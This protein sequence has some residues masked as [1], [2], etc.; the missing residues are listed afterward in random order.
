MRAEPRARRGRGLAG[1]LAG[2]LLAL[3]ALLAG[4]AAAQS[5]PEPGVAAA[6]PVEAPIDAPGAEAP[7]PRVS[8]LTMQPGEAYWARF[9]HNALLV[10]DPATGEATSYNFG[11]FDFDQ[12]GFLANFLRGEMRYRLLAIPA[13]VDIA[14]YRDEGRGVT[15]Q[16]L[17]LAPAQA[18]AL[19]AALAENARPENAEYTYR[20]FDD[21]CSTR[22]RDA[23][24]AAL[25][26]ALRPPL[27]VTSLGLTRRAEA[28]R[29]GAPLPWLWLG[30]DFGLGPE[31][32][33]VMDRWDEAFVPMRLRDALREVRLEDGRAL[34][35]Q[36]RTLVEHRLG[37]EPADPP[38]WR[39]TAFWI[40]AGLAL[41]ALAL[42]ASRPRALAA[43]AFAWWSL[44]GVLGLGLAA[45]WLLTAHTP[46]HGNENLLLA[47]PLALA[48]LPGAWALARGRDPGRAFRATLWVVGGLAGL[49]GFLKFLP[50]RIQDNVAWVWLLMPLQLALAW[51]FGHRDEAG[52]AREG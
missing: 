8:V 52:P 2:G 36:E 10:E 6:A 20:Y 11:S 22:V 33:A 3:A 17:D 44:L 27:R 50:F 29:L 13:E 40:G 26:G 51:R 16:V 24:D 45:L 23:L 49:A 18:R 32:D 4:P 5:A 30:M 41:G 34:V 39:W 47:T 28:I 31:A 19:A 12:P 21:N 48:L 9:G 42:G 15:Q 37:R 35:A 1:A 43:L 14:L 46:A 7:A 25:G 38:R